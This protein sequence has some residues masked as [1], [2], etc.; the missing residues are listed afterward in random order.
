[1]P[2]KTYSYE[3]RPISHLAPLVLTT[4]VEQVLTKLPTNGPTYSL[5]ELLGCQ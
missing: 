2:M 1:M 5:A 3:S 4:L